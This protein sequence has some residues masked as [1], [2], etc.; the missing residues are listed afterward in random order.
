MEEIFL[1]K[2]IQEK[3]NK[4]REEL[5]LLYSYQQVETLNKP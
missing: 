2:G 5:G 1:D 3:T 4:G